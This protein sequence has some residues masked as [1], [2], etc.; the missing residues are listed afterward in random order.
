MNT[1]HQVQD[2]SGCNRGGDAVGEVAA[3]RRS[4]TRRRLQAAAAVS[5][6]AG[7]ASAC[8]VG[9]EGQGENT[10]APKGPTA[11]TVSWLHW[12]AATTTF[13]KPL[14]NA[15]ARLR[16]REPQLT[17]EEIVVPNP[18]VATKLQALAAAGTPPD[19][20]GIR[21]WDFVGHEKLGL[22]LPLDALA[23]KDA[24]ALDR[25]DIWPA[26]LA[27]VTRAN[28]LSGLPVDLNVSVLLYNQDLIE[29][30]GAPA[31]ADSWKWDDLVSAA[32]RAMRGEGETKQF[33]VSLPGAIFEWIPVLWANGGDLFAKDLKSSA[34]AQAPAVEALQWLADLRHRHQVAPTAREQS[35]A[36]GDNGL[37]NTGR[38]AY[39]FGGTHGLSDARANA[40]TGWD[41]ALLPSGK[42][43]R[44]S[45]LRGASLALIQPGKQLDA[46]WTVIRALTDKDTQS[47][48]AAAGFIPG[49]RSASAPFL[50][51]LPQNARKALDMI[52]VGRDFQYIE[53][54]S[55][56]ETAVN[57]E[58]APLFTTNQK[59]ARDAAESLKTRLD[60]LVRG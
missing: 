37:F 2:Q 8:A 59:S 57:E 38:L 41:V 15:L 40:K 24:R 3:W 14:A 13:G 51:A 44:L 55:E 33:G 32:R 12:T 4:V 56:L 31:P 50:T 48:L 42:S 45:L 46:S 5:L 47:G 54:Q 28:K 25:G 43:G 19:I 27:R 1:P 60:A 49:R 18:E 26:A 11:A 30:S 29:A 9:S 6:A 53:R 10:G 34:I 7:A 22:L 35:G 39:R 21:P 52:E 58:L 16:Q 17:V 23:A 20:S 36:G